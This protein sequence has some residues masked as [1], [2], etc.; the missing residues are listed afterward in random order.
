MVRGQPSKVGDTRTSPNNYHYT[1]THKGWR[2]THHIVAEKKIGRPLRDNERVIFIDG[3]RSNIEPDNLRVVIK[4]QSSIEKE[5][6]RLTERI[7]E[8]Q[9]QL[10][11]LSRPQTRV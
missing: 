10:D 1:R 4:G 7:R 6:A 2:L 8:L 5:K 3:K 11:E 9:A